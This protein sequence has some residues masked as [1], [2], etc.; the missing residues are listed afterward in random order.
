MLK[1]H[2]FEIVCVSDKTT[3]YKKGDTTMKKMNE[4]D[5]RNVNGGRWKC[6]NC[7]Y[8]SVTVGAMH[9]HLAAAHNAYNINGMKTKN[10]KYH[11][12]VW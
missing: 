2:Q 3:S 4:K 9:L 12:C 10:W 5:M 1:P 11:W 7:K 8:K 6:G